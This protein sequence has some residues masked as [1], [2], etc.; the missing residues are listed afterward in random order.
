VGATA[1]AFMWLAVLF[2]SVYGGDLVSVSGGG[3]DSTTVPSD[4]FVA[5]FASLASVAV[6]R[7]AFRRASDEGRR[8][9][10]SGSQGPA[11]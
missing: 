4:I 10:P 8:R 11:I 2:A 1:I 9:G 5:F 6:A 3:T 7:R